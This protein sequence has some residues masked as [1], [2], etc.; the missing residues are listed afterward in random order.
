MSCNLIILYRKHYVFY[1]AIC[2]CTNRIHQALQYTYFIS[3]FFKPN[4][5]CVWCIFRFIFKFLLPRLFFLNCGYL[6]CL[7]CKNNTK[8]MKEQTVKRQRKKYIFNSKKEFVS[9]H[10]FMTSTKSLKF[11]LPA[12]SS[13]PCTNIQFWSKPIPLLD[14]LNSHANPAP[15]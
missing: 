8:T 5:T 7:S 15:V 12:P 11:E 6:F 10:S 3:C 13:S 14:V 9:V 4:E 1:R 2:N